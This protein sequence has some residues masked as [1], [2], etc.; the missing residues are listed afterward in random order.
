M[1]GG[2]RTK[3]GNGCGIVAL[4]LL[5]LVWKGWESVLHPQDSV[6][7][8]VRTERDGSTIPSEIA[9]PVPSRKNEISRPTVETKASTLLIQEIPHEKESKILVS[10]E[11]VPLPV[12]LEVLEPLTLLD[13]GGKEFLVSKGSIV[14]VSSRSQLGTLKMD[15]SRVRYVGNES[16]LSGKVR[17]R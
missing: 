12:T 5:F 13:P 2:S 8:S 16:R 17:M 9:L 11:S 3:S 15:I 7:S 10:L 14:V 1:G 4:G 6:K